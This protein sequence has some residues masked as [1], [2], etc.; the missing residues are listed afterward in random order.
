MA[1]SSRYAPVWQDRNFLPLWI[2]LLVSNLG[3]WVAY[4]A[5]YAVAYQQTHSALVLVGLRLIHLVPEF[6]FA[7]FAGV[8]VDRW[9]RKPTLIVAP[10]VSSVAVGLLAVT[11]PTALILACEAVI[12]AAAM[13]FE[14][15][16]S[17]SIPNIVAED[18]L[19]R[20]I[21]SHA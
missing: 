5:M 9:S 1:A 11:H 6:L 8:L 2:G 21:P 20:P 7:P 10:L 19:P 12:T 13:F 15:A 18:E 17:A 3:D 14:P 4:I 16:V